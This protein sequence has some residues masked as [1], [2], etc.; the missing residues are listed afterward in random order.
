[1]LNGDNCSVALSGTWTYY[2]ATT[3]GNWN[4]DEEL[5]DVTGSAATLQWVNS[6][7]FTF[8]GTK[9]PNRGILE[10]F[11]D[12]V[13]QGTFD[14]YNASWQQKQALFTVQNFSAGPHTVKIVVAG[15]KNGASSGYQ[16]GLDSVSVNVSRSGS[17]GG[18]TSFVTGVTSAGRLRNDFSG[19]VGTEV[20]VGS[21]ALT[22]SDL[23]RAM[24]AGN[25]GTHTVEIV[26]ASDGAALGSVSVNM[27]AGTADALGFKY[28]TLATPI[29]LAANTS[30]YFVTNETNSGDQWHDNVNTT[31][32]TQAVGTIPAAVYANG[33]AW[34][35]TTSGQAYGPV[36]FKYTV[37][38]GTLSIDDNAIGMGQ[39][40]WYYVGNWSYSTT[41]GDCYNGTAHWDG[42]PSDYVTI[43]FTG[44]QI[45]LYG[46]VDTSHGQGAVSIDGGAE[47]TVNFN[48]SPRV[49]NTLLWTSPVL[50][51]GAHTFKLR[52]ASGAPVPDRVVIY[53]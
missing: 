7:G 12:N 4:N 29:T 18:S 47:T 46:V 17:G 6:T 2:T 40:Q 11:V 44:T 48:G 37:S 30:Y 38:G 10:A 25:S 52:P 36:N 43:P 42:N 13:S 9:G 23:G 50:S 49:G 19:F 32:T 22:V 31:L 1:M 14:T 24:I 53:P 28:G 15:Q 21:T 51:S 26:R 5:S 8:Y 3:Q 20:T 27:G 35:T 39:N 33:G 34:V 41:C 45:A 16:I